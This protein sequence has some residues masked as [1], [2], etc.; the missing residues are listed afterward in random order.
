MRIAPPSRRSS[1]VAP[2]TLPLEPG[3]S[4]DILAVLVGAHDYEPPT[5]ELQRV[6][7]PHG[8]APLILAGVQPALWW[9]LGVA[10][11]PA[12]G[13]TMTTERVRAD[14]ERSCRI[15]IA[16][17]PDL[18]GARVETTTEWLPTTVMRYLDRGTFSRVVLLAQPR[19]RRLAQ[20]ILRSIAGRV[21][22]EVHWL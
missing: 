18:A 5:A 1:A 12:V 9:W 21:P 15:A 11:L 10:G 2:P 17:C 19:E 7:R 13:M 4:T 3:A 22:A 8:P 6:V 20:R 14:V 16:G